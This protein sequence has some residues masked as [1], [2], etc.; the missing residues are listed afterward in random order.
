MHIQIQFKKCRYVLRTRA[1][2]K[3][4]VPVLCTRNIYNQQISVFYVINGTCGCIHLHAHI[5]PFFQA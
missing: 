3:V 1:G 2:G 4:P 5:S